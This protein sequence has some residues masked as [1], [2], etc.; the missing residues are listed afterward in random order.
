M[1][2]RR[3]AGL[4]QR[5]KAKLQA[6]E[7]AKAR[8]IAE[9]ER[10]LAAAR[11]ARD[12]LFLDL[13]AFADVLEP[14]AH[15]RQGETLV[16]RRGDRFLQ[17]EPMGE[18]E[19]VRVTFTGSEGEDHRLYREAAL[20]DR[21]VWSFTRRRRGEERMPLFDDGLEELLVLALELP[22][23]TGAEPEPEPTPTRAVPDPF[24]SFAAK[25]DPE[26]PA[27]PAPTSPNKRN[28]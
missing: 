10:R 9:R 22:R 1:S 24:A 6:E 26:P 28:L 14:I 4:A 20:G 7:E 12:E 17:L 27:P 11:A 23:V 8:A 5:M 15:A 13:E 19:R 3:G 21:W 16:L 25:K 2:E 18:G